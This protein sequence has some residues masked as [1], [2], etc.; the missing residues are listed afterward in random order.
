MQGRGRQLCRSVTSQYTW[1]LVAAL[2]GGSTQAAYCM[3]ASMLRLAWRVCVPDS[4]TAR[5]EAQPALHAALGPPADTA[6]PSRAQVS[7]GSCRSLAEGSLLLLLPMVPMLVLVVCRVWGASDLELDGIRSLLDS[8]WPVSSALLT[9]AASA[10]G[11]RIHCG[12]RQSP[13]ERPH[14]S[15]EFKR[16]QSCAGLA[17]AVAAYD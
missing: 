17:S 4:L 12:R 1:K 6:C 15:R 11:C 8:T 13:T 14:L 7:K 9:S 16:N 5:Q 2:S 10:H 3:L